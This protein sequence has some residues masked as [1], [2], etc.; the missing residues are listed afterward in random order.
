MYAS[1]TPNFNVSLSDAANVCSVLGFDWQ[2]YINFIGPGSSGMYAAQ[3][4]QYFSAGQMVYAPPSYPDPP[5][6]G[7]QYQYEDPYSPVAQPNFA[8]AFPFVYSF[9][10]VQK[11]GCALFITAPPLAPFCRI[12]MASQQQLFFFDEPVSEPG[13]SKGFSTAVVG[14]LPGTS[15]GTYAAGQV[16]Q[17]F[18]WQ[19]DYDKAGVGVVYETASFRPTY[20]GTGSVTI[21]SVNGVSLSPL[22][23]TAISTT[24]SGLAYSRTSQTFNGTVTIRNISSAAIS[25]PFQVVFVS[26]PTGVTVANSDGSYGGPLKTAAVA[27]LSPSQSAT[28]SVQFK[29]PSNAIIS[30]TP[31]IY[32]GSIN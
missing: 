30:F 28:V 9:L 6:G 4:S 7:Y 23:S 26:L 1:F 5:P 14:V 12:P 21:T 25:G 16:Y 27:N 24:A 11:G 8:S 18:T 13:Q 22:A 10:D 32:S 19:T 3:T 15:S 31:V 29:N 17:G 20:G 2:Q